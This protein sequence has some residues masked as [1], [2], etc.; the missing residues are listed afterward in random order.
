MQCAVVDKERERKT[1]L[2][3]AEELLAAISASQAL[4][5]LSCGC[6]AATCGPNNE[7]LT[8]PTPAALYGQAG[9]RA[10]TSLPAC[11]G[12]EILR[13]RR[14]QLRNSLIVG[15]A[16]KMNSETQILTELC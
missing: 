6:P 12:F 2:L 13:K 10:H 9:R 16:L 8:K 5:G 15:V 3:S 1:A 4:P 11:A 7:V 14:H